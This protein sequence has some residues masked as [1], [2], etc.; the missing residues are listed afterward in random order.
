MSNLLSLK[1]W[2]M[3]RPGPL[4]PVY[5]KILVIIILALAAAG[6]IFWF[7]SK[8]R[9]AY[10]KILAKLGALSLTNAAVGAIILF[11]TYETIPV[12]S[13]RFWFI[14]WGAE[15]AIWLFFVV[16]EARKI[17]EKIKKIEEEKKYKKYL[18]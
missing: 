7:L 16:R 8:K 5:N 12:L 15:M 17:P 2:L 11:F 4:L 14:V 3:S 9:G 6:A 18:P 10:G 13:S 1:F